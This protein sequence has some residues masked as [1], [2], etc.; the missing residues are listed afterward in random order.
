R[1]AREMPRA[2]P[3]LLA[4][5]RLDV[6]EPL[7]EQGLDID[8][9]VCAANYAAYWLLRGKLAERIASLESPAEKKN[10]KHRA[11]VLAYLYRARGDL[12]AA[13]AAAERAERPDLVEN[14]LSEAG[15]WK[16]LARRPDVTVASNVGEKLGTPAAR[17]RLAANRK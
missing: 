6:L 5:D 2:V 1:L 13:R 14:L 17:Q 10:D 4:E 16:E 7:L 3:A 12:V 9:P 8:P 11:E 15:D